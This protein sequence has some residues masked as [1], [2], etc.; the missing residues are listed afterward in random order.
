MPLATKKDI[1]T[2][3][4]AAKKAF[5]SWKNVPDAKRAEAC[6]AIAA[7]IEEHAE[8]LATLLTKEQGKHRIL[9]P[10]RF[11]LANIVLCEL[12]QFCFRLLIIKHFI[13]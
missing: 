7:K 13:L 4:V 9:P 1:E 2:A 12:H 5:S 11:V 6:F 10:N 3:V 8:E